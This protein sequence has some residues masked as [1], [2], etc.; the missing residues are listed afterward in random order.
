MQ[1][2]QQKKSGFIDQLWDCREV[3]YQTSSQHNKAAV[4]YVALH[5]KVLFVAQIE[6]FAFAIDAL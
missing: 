2:K 5:I 1:Y 4:E 6:R 3:E